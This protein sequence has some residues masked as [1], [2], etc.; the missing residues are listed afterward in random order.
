MKVDP[1]AIGATARADRPGDL[2]KAAEAFEALF[3][4]TL[5]ERMRQSQLTDGFFGSEAGSSVYEGMFEQFLADELASRSPLGIARL[6][7]ERWSAEP[8]GE[9]SPEDARAILAV[10]RAG[11]AYRAAVDG[12]ATAALGPAPAAATAAGGTAP[13]RFSR[14]FGW[15]QDPIDGRSRFHGGVDMP[16]PV[17]TPVQ[18]LAAGRVSTVEERGGYGLR[19]EVE[20]AGGWATTYSHLSEADVAPGQ[21]VVRGQRIGAVGDSGRSTG[22]HLHFEA[23]KRGLKVDPGRWTRAP[24]PAQVFGKRAEENR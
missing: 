16:A 1:A 11:Q 14:N 8:E 12:I 7:E 17:G 15:G 9:T 19:I 5:V 2:R 20:H 10:E 18:A 4:Q 6:L 22:P 23:L 3:L 24:L 21:A 13:D